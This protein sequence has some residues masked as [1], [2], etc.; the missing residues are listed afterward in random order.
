MTSTTRR[1]LA[2][3]LLAMAALAAP[4]TAHACGEHEPHEAAATESHDSP[5]ASHVDLTDS[6][7]R[8]WTGR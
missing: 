5:Y 3:S 8:Y 7:S 2:V 4:G 1:L 6:P